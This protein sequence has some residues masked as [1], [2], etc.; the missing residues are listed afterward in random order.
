M[1]KLLFITACIQI[2]LLTAC[3]DFL[4]QYPKDQVYPTSTS[5]FNELLVGD[6]Y[7]DAI[8]GTDIGPWLQV[9]DDDVLFVR[10]NTSKSTE[11]N[12][13]W[14]EPEPN[15]QSTWTALYKR[16]GVVNVILNEI[17]EFKDEPGDGYRKVKGEAHFLRGSNYYFLVNIYG[18]PYSKERAATELGV[19]L[20]LNAE[21]EDKRFQRNS[22]EECYQQ[23]VNDLQ[24]AVRL[25]KGLKSTTTY[26]ANEMA[27]RLL[28]SRVFLY[29]G[30]WENVIKQ[31]DTI[32]MD[33]SYSLLDYN[34]LTT[35]SNVI[36][37]KS[38]ETIFTSG[39]T[40]YTNT[41]FLPFINYYFRAS[42]EILAAYSSN[43]LRRKFYFRGYSAYAPRKMLNTK[44]GSC[45]DFFLLRL[46][47]VYLNKAEALAMLEKTTEA[48]ETIQ[49]LREQRVKTGTLEDLQLSG[50][51][52]VNYIRNE[53]RLELTFEG[54]RWFDLRRYAVCPKWPFQKEIHHPYYV[55]TEIKGA[56]ILRKYDEEP[57]FYVL[58]LPEN[59]IVLNGGTLIQNATREQK[60][61][62]M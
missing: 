27:A 42:E 51:E 5:D 12:F 30:E 31:C 4:S 23:I 1:K 25:L 19:P 50:E 15:T 10:T 60:S 8:K 37:A 21:I 11:N 7:M 33:K 35:T 29:Q 17:D 40:T 57:E 62:V 26:R 56:R 3:H 2:L 58:P 36:S 48:I 9:M 49:T 45:S 22:L 54:Q 53:R 39:A 6:G 32:L 55:E 16:I 41:P 20:K 38:P 24:S 43:D 61:E 44:D 14:Y 46:P 59:E 28:L 34:T 52:L 18:Q 13:Y 47:E